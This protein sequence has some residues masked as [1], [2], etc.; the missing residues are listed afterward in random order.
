MRFSLRTLLIVMLLLGPLCAWCWKK[1][2]ARLAELERQRVTKALAKDGW[3]S[4]MGLSG[5]N[6]IVS[7]GVCCFPIPEIDPSLDLTAEL[8]HFPA[9]PYASVT[10]EELVNGVT[11]VAEPE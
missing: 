9:D 10:W 8:P 11:K 7:C 6:Y 4:P 3:I 1:Y 5:Q 2:Q